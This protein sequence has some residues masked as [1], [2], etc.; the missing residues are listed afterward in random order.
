MWVYAHD[1]RNAN[2]AGDGPD[3]DVGN[4][5]AA[6]RHASNTRGGM[7]GSLLTPNLL[8]YNS[9]CHSNISCP[10]EA[11][12][13]SCQSTE[14]VVTQTALLSQILLANPTSSSSGVLESKHEP[15]RAY[16]LRVHENLETQG[17]RN[18]CHLR[19][20]YVSYGGLLQH[21]LHNAGRA[22]RPAQYSTVQYMLQKYTSHGCQCFHKDVW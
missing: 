19:S 22:Q 1:A 11:L 3:V 5:G 20:K 16:M 7:T 9:R 10:D 21:A 6:G 8:Y 12:G 17:K 15:H 2:N 4:G 13:A 14:Q 18:V